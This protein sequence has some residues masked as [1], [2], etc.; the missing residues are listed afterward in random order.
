MCG[1]AGDLRLSIF[2]LNT[3]EV[4][5]LVAKFFRPKLVSALVGIQ[6]GLQQAGCSFGQDYKSTC[7]LRSGSLLV[8]HPVEILCEPFFRKASCDQY[9]SVLSTFN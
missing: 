1:Q 8:K 7:S 3:I 6:Q 2:S 9:T 5:Y 4:V